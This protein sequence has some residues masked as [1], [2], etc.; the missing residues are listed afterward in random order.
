MIKKNKATFALLI[1]SPFTF[2]RTV[3]QSSEY[4]LKQSF[5]DGLL[6]GTATLTPFVV[7]ADSLHEFNCG[8]WHKDYSGM[9]FD[10]QVGSVLAICEPCSIHI[11]LAEESSVASI[12]LL[13]EDNSLEAGLWNCDFDTSIDQVVISMSTP[14]YQRA[15]A[16]RLNANTGEANDSL[17]NCVY[18]PA[19]VWLL[20]E[21][22]KEDSD[23]YAGRAW[24]RSIE[25]KLDDMN[26]QKLGKGVDRLR[27]AQLIFDSP[28]GRLPLEPIEN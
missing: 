14:D 4:E 23:T 2:Y 19:L 16:V 9:T 27:D 15:Q 26:C 11:D 21:L 8:T 3:I 10:I 17:L 20:Q 22:D 5:R 25:Q 28:F 1:Y 13:Q 24:Y 7:A 12:F 18:F 6:A